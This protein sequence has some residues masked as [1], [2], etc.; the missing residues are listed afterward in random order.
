M[1]NTKVKF[2]IIVEETS[3]PLRENDI[4]MV[5]RII[6]LWEHDRNENIIIRKLVEVPSKEVYIIRFRT[7]S[8]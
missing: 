7:E 2:I 4:R 3:I 8:S 6:R 5:I 1:T